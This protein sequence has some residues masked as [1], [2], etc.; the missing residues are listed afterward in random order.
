MKDA[1]G[2]IL[3]AII[4]IAILALGVAFFLA[5]SPFI[6]GIIIAGIVIGLISAAIRNSKKNDYY[7]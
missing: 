1:L 2:M 5:L 3:G 4:L 6:I 7:Y